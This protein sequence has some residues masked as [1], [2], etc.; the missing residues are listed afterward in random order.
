M[1]H[2]R[3]PPKRFTGTA[4]PHVPNS[5]VDYFSV[6]Y[7]NFVDTT[8]NA[9]DKRYNQD[10]LK[11][12]VKLENVLTQTA[13]AEAISK[14][15]E[16]YPDIDPER[17][18][19]QL[20]MAKQQHWDMS[21]VGEVAEKLCSLDPAVR[22][23]FNE[24]EQLVRLLLTVPCSNAEAERSFSA[25]C[26]LKTYLR[27]TMNQDRLNHLAVLHVHQDRLD[28]IDTTVIAREFVSKCEARQLVFGDYNN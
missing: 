15:L 6:Q 9:I 12:Y 22:T 24:I 26:R 3:R 16:G 18:V 13:D 4:E 10:G 28:L 2:Q 23:M 8:V 14:V 27:N 1:P 20:A 5:S 25:F 17:L 11:K 21:S 7:F 19:V